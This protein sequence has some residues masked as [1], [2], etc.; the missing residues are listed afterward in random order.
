MTANAFK[1]VAKSAVEERKTMDE[2]F[3]LFVV[4]L[5]C[6]VMLAFAAFEIVRS[7]GTEKIMQTLN[8]DLHHVTILN[9]SVFPTLAQT[10]NHQF[11]SA[12]ATSF[13][14][15]NTVRSSSAQKYHNKVT[16]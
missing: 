2:N 3:I 5:L 14:F 15:G 1:P 13:W 10:T 11:P 16:L 8:V 12:D 9:N 7:E 4:L 6:Q